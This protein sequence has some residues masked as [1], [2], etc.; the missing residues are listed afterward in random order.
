MPAAPADLFSATRSWDLPAVAYSRRLRGVRQPPPGLR[1]DPELPFRC[2]VEDQLFPGFF[3]P[4]ATRR[5]GEY[6]DF[7]F[8]N[9]HPSRS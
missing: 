3:E 9:P 5:P 1:L 6:V 7:W 4:P 8:E 2:S